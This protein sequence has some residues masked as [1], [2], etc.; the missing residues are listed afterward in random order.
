MDVQWIGAVP[1]ASPSNPTNF[2]IDVTQMGAAITN[3]ADSPVYQAIVVA[4]AATMDGDGQNMELI[5]A[6]A[7]MGANPGVNFAPDQLHPSN[8]LGD[9]VMINLV[10][11]QAATLGLVT[12]SPAVMGGLTGQV[13]VASGNNVSTG[14]T[15]NPTGVIGGNGGTPNSWYG[16]QTHLA[17]NSQAVWEGDGTAL[18]VAQ[19]HIF[20]SY[21]TAANPYSMC[22]FNPPANP[23]TYLVTSAQF[24]GTSS[25]CPWRTTAGGNF[26]MGVNTSGL[27]CFR[28]GYTSLN[29]NAQ[30]SC[31]T[32]TDSSAHLI[33]P[34][35][36]QSTTNFPSPLY[37]WEMGNAT[38]S[39]GTFSGFSMQVV[40]AATT[41]A[42]SGEFLRFLPVTPFG[43]ATID[44]SN[45]GFTNFLTNILSSNG[46]ALNGTI[47]ATTPAAGTFTALNATSIGAT[48]PGTGAFTTLT[49]GGTN[50][51]LQSGT[52]CPLASVGIATANGFSG[53]S[54]G[55]A[56]PS[57]T[58]VAGAINPTSIGAT[59]P[60]T[61]AFSALTI[62]GNLVCEQTGTNCPPVPLRTTASVT[63][64]ISAAGICTSQLVTLTGLTSTMVITGS[65][66]STGS[67]SISASF[68]FSFSS[69]NTLQIQS[70]PIL[71]TTTSQ[72][73]SFNILAQ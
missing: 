71:A 41:G 73:L 25:G 7:A 4:E 17:T 54:S 6:R 44:F 28:I 49:A 48:T 43:A 60:G 37:T 56:N 62:A 69:T 33:R 55:G 21:N 46:G 24:T 72:T 31:P 53:T 38:G 58:I 40:P 8:P 13:N 16:L 11:S 30:G 29:T 63:I 51:C 3:F 59:T 68:I 1:A 23:N 61:G 39:T 45:T 19:G 67:V 15:I 34:F 52:N 70:C 18:N 20:A 26:D 57:L 36:P 10:V 65:P 50:V 9:N 35:N 2:E 22:Q 27:F 14:W 64:P 42:N 32:W 47:G 5:P 66:S 12:N